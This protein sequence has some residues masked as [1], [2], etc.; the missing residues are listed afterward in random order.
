MPFNGLW[1]SGGTDYGACVG[2]GNVF[3][4]A[5]GGNL[6]AP[7]KHP[8]GHFINFEYTGTTLDPGVRAIGVIVP[9]RQTKLALITDGLSQT[10]LL[11]ELQRTAREDNH[12]GFFTEDSWAIAGISNLFDTQFLL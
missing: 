5:G 10:I 12:C 3:Q 11:G 2:F 6:Y 8:F 4:D 9:G 1:D 7:C